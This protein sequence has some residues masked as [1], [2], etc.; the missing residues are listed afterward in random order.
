[1]R[2]LATQIPMAV[3]SQN[4]APLLWASLIFAS[5]CTVIGPK[6]FVGGVSHSV[7]VSREGFQ[8]LWDHIWWLFVKGWHFFEFAV[9][10]LLIRRAGAR[11]VWSLSIAVIWAALDEWHQTFVPRRGGHITDVLI[12]AAGAGVALLACE[13]VA[14][15]RAVRA[16]T[17]G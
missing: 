14:L 5:S 15:R 7:G 4:V 10:A 17:G 1:M 2:R 13:A 3:S 12:D 9:L 6:A 11:A 16:R 8:H